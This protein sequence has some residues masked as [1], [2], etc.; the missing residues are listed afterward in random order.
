MRITLSKYILLGCIFCNSLLF[1][2]QNSQTIFAKN[3]FESEKIGRN[4]IFIEEKHSLSPKEAYS[5][6]VNGIDTF[7]IAQETPQF[8][9]QNS[10]KW[11][12]FT[13]KNLSNQS[14]TFILEVA[15]PSINYIQLFAISQN[16]NTSISFQD[17][18]VS[19]DTIP[20]AQ[21]T[22]QHR[23]PIFKMDLNPNE[24]K[25]YLIHFHKNGALTLPVSIYDSSY[26][27]K[28]DG[29]T[30]VLFGIY[31]GAILLIVVI[32]MIL[33]VINRKALYIIYAFYAISL[34]F[35]VLVS[36]G[37]GFMLFYPNGT[38][39]STIA[40]GVSA[41]IVLMFYIQLTRI[42]L[43]LRYFLPKY[44]RII[45]YL[46]PLLIVFSLLTFLLINWQSASL[47]IAVYTMYFIIVIIF[48]L[49]LTAG[50]LSLKHNK[51]L[52]ILYITGYGFVILGSLMYL[53]GKI[54]WLPHVFITRNGLIL[55]SVLEI[56][57]L[58]IGLG[59]LTRKTY[60]NELELEKKILQK[61]NQL[62]KALLEG[63]NKER[64][65]IAQDL[66]DGIGVKLRVLK[67]QI[68]DQ[69]SDK[70]NQETVDGIAEE[71]RT[72]SHN[73]M[74]SNLD[75]LGLENVIKDF[76]SNLNDNSEIDIQ[77]I[78]VDFPELKNNTIAITLYRIVQECVQN[79]LKHS[80]ANMIMVQMIGHEN[81]LSITIEDDGKGFVN[82][83]NKG[84]GLKNI[85][86][87]V[88]SLNGT[89]TIENSNEIFQKQMP[90]NP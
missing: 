79:A 59:V 41:V 38:S 17:L 88:A 18:G 6:F 67:Q 51:V 5:L 29:L 84:I 30:N 86:S 69:K 76:I 8:G 10:T 56:I 19:G 61:E 24:E 87:R 60:K 81:E 28:I 73:L 53:M 49:T 71:I 58:G 42:F 27:Y 43:N 16:E 40:R 83:Q 33:G 46:N 39:F 80:Q 2:A 1:F 47:N 31:C 89:I 48:V 11:G 85:E 45:N 22:F 35:Q 70:L 52:A 78:S 57:I 63:E 9:F 54:G 36:E 62:N 12:M 7:S 15:L 21:R 74:P 32:A 72:I 77:F 50:I 23:Y 3:D 14:R 90:Q 34:L 4:I 55:G 20:F 68:A 64:M 25:T 65:R 37:Y 82:H 13:L 44:D 66:H 26:F 75:V